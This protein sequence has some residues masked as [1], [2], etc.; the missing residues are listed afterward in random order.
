VN[1]DPF[2]GGHSTTIYWGVIR[3]DGAGTFQQI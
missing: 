1:F 3:A 2:V